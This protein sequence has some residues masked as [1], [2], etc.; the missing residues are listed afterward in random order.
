MPKVSVIAVTARLGCFD[1]LV[2]CMEAQTFPKGDFEVV[3][4]DSFYEERKDFVIDRLPK[5]FRHIGLP[6]D[7]PWYDACYANNVGTREAQGELLIYFCDLNWAYP[8]FVKDH[9]DVYRTVPG[10]SMTGYCDRFPIPL[11]KTGR[12]GPGFERPEDAYDWADVAWSIF[13]DEFTS[14]FA[15]WYFNSVEPSYRER[16]GGIIPSEPTELPSVAP[17]MTFYEL[18]ADKWYGSLNESIPKAVVEECNGWNEA[19]DGAYGVADVDL[20]VRA[21]LAGWKFLVKL[22]SINRKLGQKSDSGII[23][24]RNK[25]QTRTLADNWRLFE[26][27]KA[28]GRWRVPD[29]SGLK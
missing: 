3:V 23:P 25:P 22:D 5:N 6:E 15:E 17:E 29:G 4:V 7:R 1:V 11:L 10:H 16:K 13:F 19:M 26:E 9:W 2:N 21:N 20:G 14:K 18:P 28:S 8:D 24:A 12:L 27:M